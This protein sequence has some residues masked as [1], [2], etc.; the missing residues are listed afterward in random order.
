MGTLARFSGEMAR[1]YSDM[2]LLT[3]L[4]LIGGIAQVTALLL[5]VWV[6]W[7][8][9]RPSARRMREGEGD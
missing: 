7:K 8:R 4:I 2:P 3:G 1:A 5:Y 9:I 6:M